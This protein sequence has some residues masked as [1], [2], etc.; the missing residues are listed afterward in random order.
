MIPSEVLAEERK[1]LRALPPS[2][3][4]FPYVTL[5]RCVN[6]GMVS[7]DGCQFGIPYTCNEKSVFVCREC[8]HVLIIDSH[9]EIIADHEIQGQRKQ[10]WH[11]DQWQLNYWRNSYGG[12]KHYGNAVQVKDSQMPLFES[13]DFS[14]YDRT[15]SGRDK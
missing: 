9:G 4:I 14:Q 11:Q 10:Y 12:Q 3:V 8:N 13:T 1:H 5:K 2:S 15:F 6:E 7:F